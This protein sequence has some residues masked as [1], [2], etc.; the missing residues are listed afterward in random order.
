MRSKRKP[1]EVTI[2]AAVKGRSLEQIEEV[3]AAGVLDFGENKIQ[4]AASHY[5]ILKDKP[6]KWH[7][8]G[9]L[10]TNKVKEAVR[11]FDLIHSVDSLRL[12][13]EINQQAAK[14]NK[15]Q[16]IL[17][18]VNVSV[19]AS[20]F[21]LKPDETIGLMRQIAGLKNIRVCGLMAMAPLVDDPEKVRPYFKRLKELSAISFQLSAFSHQQILSMGM[22]DDFE[23]AIEEGATLVRLGRVIFN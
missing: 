10:Q 19:E 7:F 22:S 17:L 12:A 13:E 23:V 1:D 3:I 2:L 20:K 6:L 5:E 18:E 4:E 11:I 9:H 14:I 15:L 16:D 21:G 8:I